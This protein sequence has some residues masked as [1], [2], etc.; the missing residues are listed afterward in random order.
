MTYSTTETAP[1]LE[2]I[3]D[4]LSAIPLA[5]HSDELGAMMEEGHRHTQA[6]LR[7]AKF[8]NT[9]TVAVLQEIWEVYRKN[10]HQNVFECD[11]IAEYLDERIIPLAELSDAYIKDFGLFCTNIFDWLRFQAIY[12]D[13]TLV[14]VDALIARKKVI[15]KLKVIVYKFGELTDEQKEI[16][17]KAVWLEGV[18]AVKKLMKELLDENLDADEEE[19]IKKA[20]GFKRFN[21]EDGTVSYSVLDIDEA[22]GAYI[23]T[24]LE[25]RVTFEL[26]VR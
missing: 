3:A 16:V 20:V 7:L 5:G 18:D 24:V 13:G 19:P 22:L 9:S 8:T 10:L 23:E 21:I 17:I 4:V 15:T 11:N 25:E 26:E 14:D 1:H 12:V 6:I 2:L